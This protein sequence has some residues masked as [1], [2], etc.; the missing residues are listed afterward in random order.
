[1]QEKLFCHR[2]FYAQWLPFLS[3]TMCSKLKKYCKLWKRELKLSFLIIIQWES[4]TITKAFKTLSNNY[5]II[6]RPLNPR[7]RLNNNI[8]KSLQVRSP[9]QML[10]LFRCCRILK[11]KKNRSQRKKV[12]VWGIWGWILIKTRHNPNWAQFSSFNH[13]R[14]NLNKI[15]NKNLKNNMFQMFQSR[16]YQRKLQRLNMMR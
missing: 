4:K 14:R 8:N 5:Y 2:N 7:L 15:K 13:W 1:M 11:L 6:K 10:I 16:S 3:N 9:W 12:C